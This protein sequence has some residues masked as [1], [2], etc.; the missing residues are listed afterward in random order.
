MIYRVVAYTV[1]AAAASCWLPPP[2]PPRVEFVQHKG[3]ASTVETFRSFAAMLQNCNRK[4]YKPPV[5]LSLNFT[6][7]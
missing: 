4:S 5:N 2:P 7:V 1:A 6:I 3:E